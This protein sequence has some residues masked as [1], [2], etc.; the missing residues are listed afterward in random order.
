MDF[1]GRP[2]KWYVFVNRL[3]TKNPLDLDYW[4][5]FALDFNKKA[6]ASPKKEEK[7]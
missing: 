1:T 4:V 2:M 5:S 6:K 3:G 7:Q